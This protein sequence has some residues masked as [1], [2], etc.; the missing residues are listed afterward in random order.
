MAVRATPSIHTWAAGPASTAG[1]IAQGCE[2]DHQRSH[3]AARGSPGGEVLGLGM[4]DDDRGRRLLRLELEL[5]GERD[6]D[7]AGVEQVHQD[8]LVLQVGTGWV[9]EGVARTA[10]AL[11]E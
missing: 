2:S 10:V 1:V 3:V 9:A 4:V 8:A 6:L 7:P 5:L 11:T